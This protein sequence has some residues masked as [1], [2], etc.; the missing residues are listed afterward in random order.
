MRRCHTCQMDSQ[1]AVSPPIEDDSGYRLRVKDIDF[2]G[3]DDISIRRTISREC[4]LG[5]DLPTY[6]EFSRTLLHALSRE[7]ADDADVRLQG[8][9]VRF[10]SGAHKLM[11]YDR[12][13]LAEAYLTARKRPPQNSELDV[14]TST[15]QRQWPEDAESEPPRPLR[16]LFDVMY[17]LGVDPQQS[18]YDVQISSDQLLR[19]TENELKVIGVE[20][21]EI[22]FRNP[23]YDFVRKELVDNFLLYLS[24]W[25]ERATELVQRPVTLA[26]FD[27]KGPPEIEGSALSSHYQ[28]DDWVIKR[29][30][31]GES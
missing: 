17:R 11:P 16:R 25:V 8:S 3:I 31:S 30:K 20:P 1:T 29:Y 19:I 28:E 12:S 18:D 2:L 6:A 27:S 7:G 13:E 22:R 21:D 9:S 4:P 10:F 24:A 5:M 14:V 15:I 26:I 23:E